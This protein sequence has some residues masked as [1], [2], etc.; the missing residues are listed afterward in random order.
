MTLAKDIDPTSSASGSS[1][2]A[3]VRWDL[4]PEFPLGDLLS[5]EPPLETEFHLRQLLLLFSSLEW[6]WRDR[7]DFYCAG[8]MTSYYSPNQL[9]SEDFR[10]PDFFVVLDTDRKPRNSWTVWHENGKY[11]NVIIEVLS[12]STAATDRGLKKQIYQD[13]FRTP[14]YFWFDPVTQEFQGFEL[15]RGHYQPLPPDERDWLWSQELGLFLGIQAEQLRFFTESGELALTPTEAAL[16][17]EEQR[18]IAQEQVAQAQEQAIQAQEQVA[19]A[20]EQAI[21]A[22]QEVERVQQEGAAMEALLTRYRSQFGE[23][24]EDQPDP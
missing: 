7:Q 8:N 16:A 14:E 18:A 11:P 13:T 9:K 19:Q 6:L 12:A 4:P 3:I 23:L 2:P 21:Q 17:E 24:P 15:V 20:Q 10:G 5:D 1:E 22:Q